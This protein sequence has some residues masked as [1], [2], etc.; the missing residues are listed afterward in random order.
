MKHMTCVNHKEALEVCINPDCQAKCA[1]L[2]LEHDDSC[3]TQ[4]EEC[5]L[6]SLNYLNRKSYKIVGKAHDIHV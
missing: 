2:C 3:R 4:H 5:A 6:A 1:Y